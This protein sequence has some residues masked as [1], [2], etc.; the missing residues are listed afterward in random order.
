MT[1]GIAH[2]IGFP[3]S[4]SSFP[5]LLRRLLVLGGVLEE[6]GEELSTPPDQMYSLNPL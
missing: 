6:G 5:S 3:G 4:D 2:G 1:M